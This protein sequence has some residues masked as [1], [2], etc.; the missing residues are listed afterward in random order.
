MFR[1]A[2]S[3]AR[4]ARMRRRPAGC[5]ASSPD[6][7]LVVN[8]DSQSLHLWDLRIN[9]M[10]T[11]M[12]LRVSIPNA[13]TPGESPLSLIASRIVVAGAIAHYRVRLRFISLLL[14]RTVHQGNGPGFRWT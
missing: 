1:A 7:Q 14:R 4:S 13:A 10:P 2:R 5:I 3:A 8:G 11:V 12:T 6:T 9:Y